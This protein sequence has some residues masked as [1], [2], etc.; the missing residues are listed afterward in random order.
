[1][2]VQLNIVQPHFPPGQWQHIQVL[3]S[4]YAWH[5]VYHATVASPWQSSLDPAGNHL[6]LQNTISKQAWVYRKTPPPPRKGAMAGLGAVSDDTP[7]GTGFT[8]GD[9]TQVEANPTPDVP[10]GTTPSAPIQPAN[11]DTVVTTS[12]D[13]NTLLWVL[14]GM[15]VV[16]GSLAAYTYSKKHRKGGARRRARR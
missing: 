12:G 7:T 8:S 4:A 3:P 1:M 11:A 6:L 9:Q 13:P 2:T 14:G 10:Q 15:V 16:A 5:I